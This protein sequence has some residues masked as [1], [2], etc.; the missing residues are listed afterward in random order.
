[1]SPDQPVAQRLI[2][3]RVDGPERV[4]RLGTAKRRPDRSASVLDAM[5]FPTPYSPLPAPRINGGV[6]RERV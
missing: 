5:S 1:M 6:R 4:D 3:T 2:R